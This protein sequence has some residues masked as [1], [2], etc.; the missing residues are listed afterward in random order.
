V[1]EALYDAEHE[2]TAD[3]VLSTPAEGQEMQVPYKGSVVDVLHRIRGHLAS[4]VSYAGGRTLREVRA[5]I[6]EHPLEY[7][8]PL[9]EGSFRESYER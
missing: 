1:L 7:L 2:E 4:S 9:S 6:V 5:G 8:I 3:D